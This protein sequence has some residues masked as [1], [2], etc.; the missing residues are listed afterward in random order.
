MLATVSIN[1]HTY[2][3]RDR[4]IR[5]SIGIGNKIRAI[6]VTILE[7]AIVSRFARPS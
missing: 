7:M 3:V 2:F 1:Y 6:S 5:Q 4:V